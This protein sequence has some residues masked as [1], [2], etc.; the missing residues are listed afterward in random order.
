[1]FD[2]YFLLFLFL[3]WGQKAFAGFSSP[4]FNYGNKTGNPAVNAY[5]FKEV[6]IGFTHHLTL[7]GDEFGKTETPTAINTETNYQYQ[8]QDILVSGWMDDFGMQASYLPTG[9][10][11]KVIQLGSAKT[12]Y[13]NEIKELNFSVGYQ[14]SYSI[15][16]GVNY[17][18]QSFEIKGGSSKDA[19]DYYSR[20]ESLKKY[21]LGTVYNNDNIFFV[22]LGANIVT[23]EGDD[24][25]SLSWQ[26]SYLS[27]TYI[28]KFS[29]LVSRFELN[30]II[31][32]EAK[33]AASGTKSLNHHR[34]S[35]EMQIT[36]E[37]LYNNYLLPIT[38]KSKKETAYSGGNDVTTTTLGLGLVY[39][40]PTYN[41]AGNMESITSEEGVV[42]ESSKVVQLSFSY[43]I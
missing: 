30:Y 42:K 21:G 2:K 40:F 34:E 6:A 13:T 20:K 39:K 5:L 9:K 26:E 16:L 4:S 14:L 38:Y 33:E 36:G 11:T 41:I 32:P 25:V 15:A 18:T 28:L 22:G 8:G 7:G 43:G 17:N 37:F 10:I 24:F 19:S 35:N 3:F 23:S 31:T 1:M 27:T 12:Y 29:T